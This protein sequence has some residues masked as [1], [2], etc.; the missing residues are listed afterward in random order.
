MGNDILYL[1]TLWRFQMH[2][3]Q[4]YRAYAKH[5]AI[6]SMCTAIIIISAWLTIPFTVSFTL[7]TLSIFVICSVFELKI[8]FAS[9][10]LYI[11]LGFCG[12]PV[13]SGFSSGLAAL[14]GPT[15]G[16]ILSFLLIPP[17]IRA[18]NAS[19]KRKLA[20]SMSVSL[21]MCYIIGTLW[22]V[23]VYGSFTVPNILSALSVCVLP[24]ILP[25]IAKIIAAV[26]LSARLKTII[27]L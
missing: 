18:F 27:K 15:G 20:L 21:L 26:F 12:L 11:L 9:V 8:S 10:A 23:A 25:D 22:F 19:T 2:K 1:T 4:G 24:L 17:I 14:M 3:K 7:Q 5:M 13:F 16:F 6:I